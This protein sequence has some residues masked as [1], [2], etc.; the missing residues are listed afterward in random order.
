MNTSY[1]DLYLIHN[2][3]LAVPDIP[4]VWAQMEKVVEDGLAK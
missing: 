2:P 3:R 4:T 1:V